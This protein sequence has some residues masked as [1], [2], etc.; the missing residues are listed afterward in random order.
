MVRKMDMADVIDQLEYWRDNPPPGDMTAILAALW[1]WK[2]KKA[3]A[4][5]A[6]A[7]VGR[8]LMADFPNGR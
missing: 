6:A 4:A 3:T 2:P 5:T 8:S 1:G 7:T